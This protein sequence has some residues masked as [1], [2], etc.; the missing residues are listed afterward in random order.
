V[1]GSVLHCLPDAEEVTATSAKYHERLAPAS[2]LAASHADGIVLWLETAASVE[3]RFVRAGITVTADTIALH[4]AEHRVPVP[5]QLPPPARIWVDRAGEWERLDRLLTTA[6]PTRVVVT[7]LGGLAGPAWRC[8]GS[9][10]TTT[11]TPLA[12]CTSTS[13][14]GVPIRHRPHRRSSPG[15]CVRSVSLLTACQARRTNWSPCTGRSPPTRRWPCW[16]TTP[17]PPSRCSPWYRPQRA[18][19]S[20][21]PAAT[22]SPDWLLQDS[23][24]STSTASS[25]PP[26]P[27]SWPAC[28]T[29]TDNLWAKDLLHAL[30]ARCHGHLLALTIAGAHLAGVRRLGPARAVRRRSATGS[31]IAPNLISRMNPTPW[32]DPTDESDDSRIVFSRQNPYVVPFVVA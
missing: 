13:T 5:R 11:A 18:A 7:G 30:A 31:N 6:G 29:R 14:A 2:L 32:P 27:R 17:A 26:V 25:P 1:A 16:S 15:G 19:R 24:T 28:S 23:A 10:R 20:W 8:A 9:T 4:A 12:C 3:V 21:S 22:V